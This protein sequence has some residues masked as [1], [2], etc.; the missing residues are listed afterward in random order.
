MRMHGAVGGAPVELP[1]AAPCA[2]HLVLLVPVLYSCIAGMEE[3]ECT[4]PKRIT[5]IT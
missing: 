1:A 2:S 5:R 3:V 4:R